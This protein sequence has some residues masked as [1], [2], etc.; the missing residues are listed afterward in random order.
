MLLFF[1]LAGGM[2]AAGDT[3]M[4]GIAAAVAR[5]AP[6][7][8]LMSVLHQ[9]SPGAR[10]RGELADTK[11]HK[12][13]APRQHALP[14]FRPRQRALAKVQPPYP[15]SFVQPLFAANKP[16]LA[17]F[18]PPTA[19]QLLFAALPSPSYL[20]PFAP[21]VFGIL[22]GGVGAPGGGGSVPTTP[23]VPVV[24]P[25]V[26]PVLPAVP[27]PDSWALMLLGFAATGLALRR[28]AGPGIA[29]SR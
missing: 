1:A 26:T 9:R 21:G 29:V 16:Q 14:K 12:R 10:T 5:S 7:R 22:P 3:G 20:A 28:R 24:T 23:A 19:P 11:A 25:I 2:M 8:S 13:A 18:A 15:D 27:E 17:E 6:V 4:G